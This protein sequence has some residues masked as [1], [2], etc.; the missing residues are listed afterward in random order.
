VTRL[1]VFPPGEAKEDWKILR[2]LAE[3][4][5]QAPG[6]DTLE[7][8]RARLAEV[9]AVFGRYEE[10]VPAAWEAFGAEG[11]VAGDAKLGTNIANYYMT[12]PISRASTTM[13]ECTAAFVT[14]SAERTGTHG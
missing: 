12:D 3:V 10:L 2:A 9:N 7:Q 11:D 13:A 6:Y 8:V 5:G 4:C 1:A 14:I